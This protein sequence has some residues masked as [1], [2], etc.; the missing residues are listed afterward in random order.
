MT[1][2]KLPKAEDTA[3]AGDL[4]PAEAWAML[5]IDGAV[6]VD[7]RTDA[8]SSYVGRPDLSSFGGEQMMLSWQVFPA[9][10][11]NPEFTGRLADQFADRA[12]P[13]LFLCRS[14]VRSRFAAAAAQNVGFTRTYNILEGFEGDKDEAGHRGTVGGWKIAGLPWIQG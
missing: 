7:V 11:V 4:T 9:M 8:E 12:T 6:L 1:K 14:G 13:L 5:K 10:A 2:L 3:Y